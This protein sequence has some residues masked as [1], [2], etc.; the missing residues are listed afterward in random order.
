MYANTNQKSGRTIKRI[1][2]KNEKMEIWRQQE[3]DVLKQITG[4]QEQTRQPEK[5]ELR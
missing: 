3:K 4:Q 2:K 5:D 1:K